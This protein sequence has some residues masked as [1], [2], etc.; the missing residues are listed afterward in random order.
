MKKKFL[1]AFT[2]TLCALLCMIVVTAHP[3]RTDS[4]GGHY[5]RSTGEYHYHHGESAHDHYDIDGD[6]T[7]DCPRGFNYIKVWISAIT[8]EDIFILIAMLVGALMVGTFIVSILAL[9]F[10]RLR[11]KGKNI[12]DRA[13]S[14]TFIAALI[15]C[16]IILCLWGGVIKALLSIVALLL[17]AAVNTFIAEMLLIRILE[18]LSIDILSCKKFLWISAVVVFVIVLALIL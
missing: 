15:F 12:S 14:R 5:D 16:Y 7:I 9:I 3:G 4:R 1:I 17:F 2:I 6:G 11:N 13:E 10:V 18:V 8:G